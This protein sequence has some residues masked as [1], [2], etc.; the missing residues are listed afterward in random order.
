[1]IGSIGVA[2]KELVENSLDAGA[3]SIT[4]RMKGYGLDLIEVSDNGQGVKATDY[5]SL[6]ICFN[7]A[8]DCILSNKIYFS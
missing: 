2:I 6:G 1:V 5:E 4:V 8:V 7:V 3:T